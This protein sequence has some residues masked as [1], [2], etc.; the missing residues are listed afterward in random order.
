MQQ[1]QLE[2]HI[3]KHGIEQHGHQQQTGDNFNQRVTL[4]VIQVIHG[5]VQFVKQITIQ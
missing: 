5:I 2:Q 4:I 3:P 1:Q